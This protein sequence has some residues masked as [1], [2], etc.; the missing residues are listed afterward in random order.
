MRIDKRKITTILSTGLCILLGAAFVLS[1]SLIGSPGDTRESRPTLIPPK[2]LKYF[3]LGYQDVFADV[4]WLRAIQDFDFCEDKKSQDP[5]SFHCDR[6]WVYHM[7][8]A[9]TD[10]SPLFRQPYLTGALMLTV[11]VNDNP[12][13]SAIFD[14]AV[15]QFPRDPQILFAASYQALI[16]EKNE[17][18]ASRLLVEA[19]KNGSPPWVF[20]LA[21]KLQMRSGRLQMA[22]QI[23][24]DALEMNPAGP[25]ANRIQKRLDEIEAEQKSTGEGL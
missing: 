23:L 5:K 7:V 2:D 18:K 11:L 1:G 4:L 6:G 12:G 3:T 16:E 10:L 22:R 15:A 25:G 13:S 9:I 19:G 20:A 14:K 21:A 24:E 17:A 8:D